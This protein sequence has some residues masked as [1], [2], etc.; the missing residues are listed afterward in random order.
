LTYSIIQILQ[1][2]Y[3][4]VKEPL[5]EIDKS[6]ASIYTS[7]GAPPP[8]GTDLN[9]FRQKTFAFLVEKIFWLEE[10]LSEV[11]TKINQRP[12]INVLGGARLI[13]SNSSVPAQ[14]E[15]NNVPTADQSS[16]TVQQ[17]P[18]SPRAEPQ[19]QAIQTI[20]T[21]RQ[22]EP[23]KAQSPPI[24]PT[25]T[26]NSTPIVPPIKTEPHVEQLASPRGQ[27]DNATQAPESPKLHS[28][29]APQSRGW[30]A[31]VSRPKQT[32]VSPSAQNA[33]RPE[34]TRSPSASFAG[35][36][37]SRPT[38]NSTFIGRRQDAPTE[39]QS[40][41]QPTQ[42]VVQPVVQPTTQPQQQVQPTETPQPVAVQSPTQPKQPAPLSQATAKQPTPNLTSQTRTTPGR[43]STTQ[44][45]QL[46]APVAATV[47]NQLPRL[48]YTVSTPAKLARD[49]VY[50]TIKRR[51]RRSLYN[52]EAD[53]PPAFVEELKQ[54]GKHFVDDQFKHV[55]SSVSEN[56]SIAA[57]WRRVKDIYASPALFIEGYD[58][59][60]PVA[61]PQ[62][63]VRFLSILSALTSQ[64]ESLFSLFGAESVETGA[65]TIRFYN[66]NL[67]GWE[68]IVVDDYVP[69]DNSGRPLFTSSASEGETWPMILEKA[70][71]KS[72][73]SYGAIRYCSP[74]F[75]LSGLTGAST[76]KIVVDST[77]DL[78]ML[79]N[80]L[81]DHVQHKNIICC[82]VSAV[83]NDVSNVGLIKE[84]LYVVQDIKQT[85]Q[86]QLL[87]KLRDNL[88]KSHWTGDFSAKSPK[89][90][91]ENM[92]E[93]GANPG[94][95]KVFWM[96]I[97]DF[98][99][100][101]NQ[102]YI[103]K[104]HPIDWFSAVIS[105]E[106]KEDL[107]WRSGPHFAVAT[108]QSGFLTV[109]LSQP[110]RFYNP[111][112][113]KNPL[114][115]IGFYLVRTKYEGLK[116]LSLL[117]E[118]V[119]Y[120]GEFYCSSKV[121]TDFELPA[122]NYSIIPMTIQPKLH[123]SYSL[124][125]ESSA[126]FKI[127]KCKNWNTIAVNGQW[128]SDSAG[129]LVSFN[130]N[131]QYAFQMPSKGH[132][133]ITLTNAEPQ[134]TG[135]SHMGFYLFKRDNDAQKDQVAVS[136][137]VDF[138]SSLET[139]LEAGR[140]AI[141]PCTWD[142]AVNTKF[143]LRIYSS[144]TIDKIE[145]CAPSK[146]VNANVTPITQPTSTPVTQPTSTGT[147][148]VTT[149]QPTS[150]TQPQA[151]QTSTT[152]Q[153]P[154]VTAVQQPEQHVQQA[155]RQSFLSQNRAPR[156][157]AAPQPTQQMT[158]VVHQTSPS[159]AQPLQQQQTAAT[160]SAVE[161]KKAGFVMPGPTKVATSSAQTSNAQQLTSNPIPVQPSQQGPSLSPE[162]QAHFNALSGQVANVSL[163]IKQLENVKNNVIPAITSNGQVLQIGGTVRV[164]KLELAKIIGNFPPPTAPLDQSPAPSDQIGRAKHAI[165]LAIIDAQ[166]HLENIEAHLNASIKNHVK[167]AAI[168]D[169]T[170][171]L[172][173]ILDTLKK[174]SV[175]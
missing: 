104:L 140:Y 151:Q 32:I 144:N 40:T 26:L 5:Q 139:T 169:L 43:A 20:Q 13:E 113:E 129:G 149:Q 58:P 19:P 125:I 24:S 47:N 128:A 82:E 77:V 72:L 170:E 66:D 64:L 102:F 61:G 131:P 100:Y 42:P 160:P 37:G 27:A 12:N 174:G 23:V 87:V 38:Q 30:S 62:T 94:E 76:D 41:P 59:A 117:K 123:S 147:H 9:L 137:F 68:T 175:L 53:R 46:A 29:T 109:S 21:P 8:E 133:T 138:E 22:P 54:S 33:E 55:S 155:P 164:I 92:K 81:M 127:T 122:G 83:Q 103:C 36:M 167:F 112:G 136:P 172:A 98:L 165:K 141:V 168:N 57:T 105:G 65:Y 45:P 150:V 142:A 145:E 49:S 156:T 35:K 15:T 120:G 89:W 10:K 143:V 126:E 118:D 44:R 80:L 34:L 161:P 2:T 79:L 159:V 90:T 16:N 111:Q 116:N 3:E 17:A 152:T 74:E 18:L 97:E 48:N 106:W 146:A 135:R 86:N 4:S 130:A 124:H 115:A 25:T 119:I 132:V 50:A 171:P 63:D 107:G 162:E 88:N 7:L 11:A 6:I 114:P 93:V 69:C 85:S 157:S 67:K 99:K 14:E 153:Q 121:T 108:T 173:S 52:D 51:N 134:S 101:F 154:S 163:A 75:V 31:S 166:N 71:A 39:T 78:Q 158:P 110:Q 70:Y 1:I 73:G 148:S 91:P 60:Q 96:S 84:H 28:E 95:E 56:N